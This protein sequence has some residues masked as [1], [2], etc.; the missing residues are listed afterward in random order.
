MVYINISKH[1]KYEYNHHLQIVNTT[2]LV[3]D[4]VS[5]SEYCEQFTD[6]SSMKQ[7]IMVYFF[8]KLSSNKFKTY[9]TF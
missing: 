5:I 7:K 6:D 2:Q 1:S 4:V 9:L 8:T 3:D